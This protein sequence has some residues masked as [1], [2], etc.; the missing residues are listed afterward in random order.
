MEHAKHSK[1]PT[2]IL[3]S[4]CDFR[5]SDGV[6][7]HLERYAASVDQF[8]QVA[9]DAHR[10]SI[11]DEIALATDPVEEGELRF[12]LEQLTGEDSVSTNRLVWGGLLV[13]VYASFE[14]GI[15]Q[16]FA[17]WSL[18]TGGQTFRSKKREGLVNEAARHASECLSLSLFKNSSER[19]CLDQ[20]RHLRISFVHKGGRFSEVQQDVWG[21]IQLTKGSGF[22][23]EVVD[24]RWC[25]NV[26]AA[27]HYISVTKQVLHRFSHEVFADLQTRG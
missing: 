4:G 24:E 2:E 10:K 26:F 8:L 11:I 15:E 17:H 6:F 3:D 21:A 9:C 14:Q 18:V 13:A 7:L 5:W 27:Q 19:D 12:A 23:L 25:A 1:Y 16:L 20:L 22:P